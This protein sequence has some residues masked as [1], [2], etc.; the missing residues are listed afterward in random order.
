MLGNWD[1]IGKIYRLFVIDKRWG[2]RDHSVPE[3]NPPVLL[4]RCDDGRLG[5]IHD[6]ARYDYKCRECKVPVPEGI[7]AVWLLGTWNYDEMWMK[8]RWTK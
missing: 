3:N 8:K 1:D 7:Q 4:H 2:I 6:L 5:H